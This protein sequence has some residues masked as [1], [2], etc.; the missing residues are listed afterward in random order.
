M[1]AEK[2]KNKK[3][4]GK[5]KYLLAG[6]FVL[7]LAAGFM[8]KLGDG[9]KAADDDKPY[10]DINYGATKEVTDTGAIVY[11][12]TQQDV[13]ARL[14]NFGKW[15]NQS[16]VE[17]D[18]FLDSQQLGTTPIDNGRLQI[19]KS[20][21]SGLVTVIYLKALAD[22]DPST[23][24]ARVKKTGD[25][26]YIDEI[27][28]VINVQFKISEKDLNIREFD[29]EH[30]L[31][32][33]T[34]DKFEEKLGLVF[35]L[36]G[37]DLPTWKTD[38]EHI[39]KMKET[40][41]NG[42]GT[43]DSTDQGKSNKTGNIIATGAGKTRIT[44]SYDSGTGTAKKS[45]S[46]TV[47]VIP[48]AIDDGIG[49]NGGD[50]LQSNL[51]IHSGITPTI[52]TN[53]DMSLNN[54]SLKQKM[55]WVVFKD[56]EII[57]DSEGLKSELIEVT[58][59][60]TYSE[61]LDVT[62]KAGEY[63]I[64]FYPNEM[65]KSGMTKNELKEYDIWFDQ[66]NQ[67]NLKIYSECRDMNIILQIGDSFDVR[68][69]F[70]LPIEGFGINSVVDV[71][72][73]G[74][75]GNPEACT[76]EGDMLLAHQQSIQPIEVNV[77]V[78]GN[79][80]PFLDPAS[81]KTEFKIYVQIVN[82]FSLD[83]TSVT[84]TKGSTLKLRMINGDSSEVG[85]ATWK[86]A[87]PTFVKVDQN[88]EITGVKATEDKAIRIT[89]EWE[90]LS[91]PSKGTIRTASCQVV[92]TESVDKIELVPKSMIME[93]DGIKVINAKYSPENISSVTDK[94][95]WDVMDKEILEITP[96]EDR[97]SAQVKGLKSGTTIV[98]LLNK[99]NT[100]MAYCEVTVRTPIKT[101]TLDK[102]EL[103]IK[104]ARE[105]FRLK[106]IY[107]PADA[108]ITDL[109]WEI[110]KEGADGSNNSGDTS[111]IRMDENDP[112]LFHLVGPGTAK[113]VVQP[114]YNPNGVSA[115]CIVTVIS[116]A[117]DFSLSKTSLTL[118]QGQKEQLK[119][120]LTPTGS[121]SNI[122]WESMN[123]S[124]ATVS[125]DGTVTA[126]GP[127]QT[128]I[129][130]ISSE[131][132]LKQCQVTVTQKASGIKLSTYNLLIKVG[133]KVKVTAT[134]NPTTS[135]ET[136]YTWT[137]KDASVAAVTNEGEVTGVAAGSTIIL[138]KTKGGSVEYLYVTVQDEVKGMKLNYTTKTVTKGKTTTLKPE[139]T[140]ANASN[141]NVTWT[142]SDE[143]VATVS[144]AGKVK[145]IKGGSAI[146]TCVSE[147]G[148]YVATCLIKVV[149]PTTS[150][151]L[152]KKSYTLGVG[153][154]VKLKATLKSTSATNPKLKWTTSNKKVAVVSS[155]GNVRGKSVGTC[156][157][158]VTTTD[159]SKK[160]ASCKIRVIRPVTKIS[161]NK[162]VI[163]LVKGHSTTVKATVKPSNATEKKVSW[164]SSDKTVAVVFGGKITGLKAGTATIRAKAKDNSGKSAVCY[165]TVIDE[166]PVSSIVLSAQDLT[167]VKGQKQKVN[168]SIVP[169]NT[170]DKVKFASDNKSVATV[171]SNGTITAKRAGLAH[172][173]IVT[174]SG[175]TAVVNV[176]VIGLNKTKM[177]MEQYDTETLYV[178][179]ATSGVTWFSSAPSVATV[180]NGTVVARKPG[181]AYIYAK[182]NGISLSCKVVVTNIK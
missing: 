170:T 8:L 62:G 69:A 164:S 76:V 124:V 97:K 24:F 160:T 87:D 6:V 26:A 67:L 90:V 23:L 47:F 181:T 34:H 22:G 128:Y 70:N 157:I 148:G 77:K 176:T 52:R 9:A 134:P 166:I 17:V 86:S 114:E 167:M 35:A 137:S 45:A 16:D 138:V 57:A 177:T 15:E 65:Y 168:Y 119:A 11:T 30:I 140:P 171:S 71:D 161:L 82:G 101:L 25:S 163:T 55:S 175:K 40:T 107:T 20:S 103:T 60:G 118:E 136:K 173:T 139:F 78:S 92:V 172:I 152:N 36:A 182:Y 179:G 1:K 56:E 74:G 117:S 147:D 27:A 63:V 2:R 50:I 122:T 91:G 44:V 53:A 72:A 73:G 150:L 66:V 68:K 149:E 112:G 64:R 93:V 105:M 37:T 154:T 132:K 108:T 29:G 43:G 85:K 31:I 83:R 89:L 110:F 14:V 28:C 12:L 54:E 174:T 46:I 129:V 156:T 32:M 41:D 111:V 84:I 38:N 116:S 95:V 113:V 121:S 100:I 169:S 61:W 155:N 162:R 39:V 106:P 13:T 145:G 123:K 99:D 131:G 133:E 142:S 115:M 98:T 127:G 7:C 146:V 88:G 141:K 180:V 104:T 49:P 21:G 48:T 96:S 5:I 58:A 143:K 59:K 51:N 158:K 18:W 75:I 80:S 33:N 153:K 151:K 4:L 159:G 109:K 81:D 10:I 130:A 135:T 94:F 144:K 42:G 3:G 120:T 19:S 178:D 79:L 102:T 165:V 126:V 125:N